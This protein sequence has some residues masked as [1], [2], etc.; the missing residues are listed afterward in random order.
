MS[1]KVWQCTSGVVS[2]GV[3]FEVA[4]IG[5]ATVVFETVFR[6]G[7]SLNVSGATT[8]TASSLA[9]PKGTTKSQV[10]SMLDAQGNLCKR[11]ARW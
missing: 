4:V 9:I 1:S 10:N 3:V 7:A 2:K 5:G 8:S 6:G 11:R